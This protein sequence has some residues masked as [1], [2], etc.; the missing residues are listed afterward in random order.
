V[1]D[2][3]QVSDEEL[4]ASLP[5][6]VRNNNPLN[7]K[8]RGTAGQDGAFARYTSMQEGLDAADRNLQAYHTKHGIN[9]VS[10]VVNR[11]A[12][13]AADGNHTAAYT[14]HVAQRMGVDPNAPLDM[15]SAETR[16]ALLGAMGEFENGAP[17]A[18]A[19]DLSKVSDAD[20]L[21]S[22]NLKPRTKS[23][24]ITTPRPPQ[25]QPGGAVPPQ[26]SL[27]DLAVSGFAQPFRTLVD[28]LG[29]HYKD[30]TSRAGRNP[31]SPLTAA[32]EGLSDLGANFGLI[33]DVLGLAGAPAV[34][35]VRPAAAA[36]NKVATPTVGPQLTFQGGRPGLTA[37]R[38]LQGEEAQRFVENNLM[39]ALSAARP[40][41]VQPVRAPI[42]KPRTLEDL[43]EI[44]RANWRKVDASTYKFPK[45]DADAAV[46][47]AIK[48]VSE[49]DPDL[50]PESA[51]WAAKLRRVADRDELTLGKLNTLKSQMR[52]QLLSPT[53]K[54]G[55]VG[56]A[57]LDAVE[58]LIATAK[59]PALAEARQSY[60]QVQKYKA[61]SDRLEDADLNRAAAGTGGNPNAT[62]QALKPLIKKKGPQRMRNLTDDEAAALRSVVRGTPTQN[63]AR[64][65][66]AFDP[67]HSRLAALVQGGLGIKTGGLSTLSIPVG[68]AGTAA[69]KAIAAKNIQSLLDLISIGGVKPVAP[70]PVSSI[71]GPFA[72]LPLPTR[73][74]GA[75]EFAQQP[76]RAREALA[77]SRETHKAARKPTRR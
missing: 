4:L 65:A 6:G 22:L 44:D 60:K 46:N 72:P 68:M 27:G 25:R 16:R 67:F 40:A 58:Q 17:V 66:S 74:L 31:V 38:K 49:A 48:A 12:P 76:A 11:W 77:V 21:A 32:K 45:A 53:S 39:T 51:K 18:P 42:P 50:Y 19:A 23:P 15:T 63:L 59:D 14:A 2:L 1:T 75:A 69:D 61:I 56:S 8:A 29:A 36:M 71:A 47:T 43:E 37:P 26:S 33:G 28:D 54:E 41:N 62:R 35:A 57:M 55:S 9:T 10:G 70:P 5:R 52:E 64:A 24:P 30:V 20:L 73:L 34:A 7:L 3:S 13:P